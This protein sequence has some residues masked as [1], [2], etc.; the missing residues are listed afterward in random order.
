MPK[1]IDPVDPRIL[2]S[3]AALAGGRIWR[4]R[5]TEIQ[6]SAESGPAIR[7]G[8]ACAPCRRADRRAAPQA[9]EPGAVRGRAPDRAARSRGSRGCGSPVPRRARTADARCLRDALR[10]EATLVP[11]FHLL[12]TAVMQRSRGFDVAF[13]GLEDGAPF[14]LLLTRDRAEAEVACDVISAEEGRGV[15]RGAWFRLADRIDPDSADLACRP[16]RPLFA[17]DDAAAGAAGRPL[18]RHGRRQS[19]GRAART[20]PHDAGDQPAAPTTTRP[21]CCGWTRCCWPARRP[22]TTGLLSSLRRE[23]GPEAHLSVTAAGGGVFVMAA[24]A[25][26]ENEIAVAIRKRLATLA[27]TRLTGDPPGHS[28]DVHRGHRPNRVARPARATRTGRRDR[29]F[30]AGADARRVVAVTC[31]SRLEM[32]GMT[33][34]DVAPEGELRFRNPAHPAAKAAALAPAV[35]SSV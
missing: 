23:F 18:R 33:G 26:Q 22:T 11:L 1:L 8:D 7:P 17:E 30:L 27:P 10:G 20:H 16:S 31:A 12:R 14:D 28:R 2:D 25:G 9:A 15:H 24:R 35:L 19:A 4:T 6:R 29:Q 13:A 32:F 3:F 34:S 5:L 21:S